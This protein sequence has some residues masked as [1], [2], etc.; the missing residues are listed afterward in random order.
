MI[1]VAKTY[2]LGDRVYVRSDGTGILLST[3]R[4]EKTP[5]HRVV[6]VEACIYLDGP[7]Q[8]EL[9]KFLREHRERRPLVSVNN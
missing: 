1:E 6:V 2:H 4:H 9:E 8:E 5:T 3:E 7:V